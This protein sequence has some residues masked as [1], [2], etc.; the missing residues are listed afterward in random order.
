MVQRNGILFFI[1]SFDISHAFIRQHC[2][3]ARR[4]RNNS[5]V[6][7]NKINTN[8]CHTV[9][10]NGREKEHEITLRR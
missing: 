9:R 4:R 1:F 6:E 8:L 7:K 5:D 2:G 3:T 10:R